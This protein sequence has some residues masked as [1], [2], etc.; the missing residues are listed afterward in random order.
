VEDV[1]VEDVG[2]ED[3]GVEDVGVEDVGV[4]DVGVED[5]G[6]VLPLDPWAE[7]S[8]SIAVTA[9]PGGRG[10]ATPL[11]RNAMV[12]SCSSPR[13]KAGGSLTTTG[14]VAVGVVQRSTSTWPLRPAY[15]VP[16]GQRS[17]SENV[18]STV[19][20]ALRLPG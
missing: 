20:P 3:V 11:G 15:L 1:G 6:G 17:P 8:W 13:R 5:V 16:F 9:V 19:T 7:A 2:V 10:T 4:E 14:L 12:S 18:R